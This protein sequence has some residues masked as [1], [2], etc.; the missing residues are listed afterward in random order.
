MHGIIHAELKKY[1][2]NRYNP[3]TW[4]QLLDKAGLKGK[5]Y[6]AEG[7][8]DDR[9]AM[10]I[11]RTACEM[12][13][14]SAKELLEDFGYFLAPGLFRIYGHLM[15]PEWK[16]I[17]MLLNTENIIHLVVRA[18]HIGAHP[19]KLRFEHVR[20]NELEISLQFTQA[21]VG[22]GQRHHQRGGGALWGKSK[23]RGK[24]PARRQCGD[25]DSG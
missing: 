3:E 25:E 20:I 4:T 22:C 17:E 9:E 10:A 11:V 19:P 2:E 14:L 8:Y 5:E 15:D 1:V 21:N 18:R 16:T 12:T 6:E 23:H 7:N 24:A 13:G